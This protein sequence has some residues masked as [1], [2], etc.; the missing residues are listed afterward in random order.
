MKTQGLSRRTLLK[1]G[2]VAGGGLAAF[3]AT[4]AFQRLAQ[5]APEGPDLYYVFAYFS[6]GWDILLGLDPRDPARFTSENMRTTRIQPAYELLSDPNAMPV[7][8]GGVLFGPY[9]GGLA[10]HADKVAIVR[11]M[12]METLTHEAGRRRFLTGKPPSGLLA[13]GSSAA[14]L[15]AARMGGAQP[16]PNLAIQVE[17]YNVDQPNFA[18]GLKANGVPD[19]IRALRPADPLLESHQAAQ[20]DHLLKTVARC[21]AAQAS[22]TWQTAEAARLKAK[23]MAFG[24]LDGLFDFFRQDPV[25]EAIR[26]HYAIPAG[27]A[28]LSSPEAQAAMAAQA[29]KG[30]VSRAVSI[31][32]ASG[33]DTHFQEWSTDQGPRQ[34]RGFDA[35]AR[36]IEDLAA[37]PYR[38]TGESWL[39]HTVIVGFS[40]F[41][42]TALLN[43]RE[44]RDHSLTNAC[45][46][47][48]AGIRGGQVVGRSS[49]L[50][51]EPMQVDLQTG[52][53]SLGG[54]I[55]KPEHVIQTLLHNAG[56]TDDF[57]DLR[58]GPIAALR[59]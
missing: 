56:Y 25:M 18:T 26:G 35:V 30:G 4:T 54:E 10:E 42:R 53:A 52:Q 51:M 55:I 33:L 16:I 1:G 14:T 23:D 32:V 24:G 59:R 48:G 49:D 43:A 8:R 5:A 20:L 29:I 39:D 36:L 34:Q 46:V 40:E 50:G 41:S 28:G 38:D 6:G 31:Q 19:L 44:G 9:A 27:A 13:R 45:F 22:R 17:S 57:A 12:S 15:L 58:V 21:D 11:G 37:S 3:G 7:E 2:L 47:A